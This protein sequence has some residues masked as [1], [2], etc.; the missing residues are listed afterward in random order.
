[1]AITDHG[2]MF[3][4]IE[5][6]LVGMKADE[7][8]VLDVDFPADWRAPQF[9]GRTVNVHLKATKVSEPVLPEVDAAFIKSFGI[10]RRASSC[11]RPVVALLIPIA[12][13]DEKTLSTA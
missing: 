11:V 2:T 6:A 7:E 13:T 10:K 9:A 3:A 5:S 8:K 4:A 12:T 1:M